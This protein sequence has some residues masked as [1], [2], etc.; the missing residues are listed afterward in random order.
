MV[1]R[2]VRTLGIV[3][4]LVAPASARD[5]WVI[6]TDGVGPVKI[7]MTLAQLNAA[8]HTKFKMPTDKEE[9]PCFYVDTPA[10]PGVSFMILE[11]RVGRADIHTPRLMTAAGVRVS[12]YE[13]R[14]RRAYGSKVK[15]EPNAYSG[16][17]DPVLTVFTSDHRYGMT[18]VTDHGN[19]R[20]IY[21]GSSDAIAFIEGCS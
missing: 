11:G 9:Q 7:G 12:D 4:L 15:T 16:P 3:A 14:V 20:L 5:R 18:F 6:H 8:L 1:S 17:E 21:A 19:I 13:K 2:I 10:Q